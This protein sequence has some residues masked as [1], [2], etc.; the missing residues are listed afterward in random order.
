MWW[1][2]LP[3]IWF[4][5]F[6]FLKFHLYI[7]KEYVISSLTFQEKCLINQTFIYFVKRKIFCNWSF[8]WFLSVSW[9]ISES[10]YFIINLWI[11]AIWSLKISRFLFY[12]LFLLLFLFFFL[13]KTCFSVAI[14]CPF[15]SAM[16]LKI[17]L[18]KI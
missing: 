13:N 7:F 4:K 3:K 18:F 15:L 6:F 11:R 1:N 10:H 2:Y 8:T 5:F 16:S 14:I 9:F 17:L 12:W